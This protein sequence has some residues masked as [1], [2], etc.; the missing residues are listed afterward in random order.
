MKNKVFMALSVL[1]MLFQC[2]PANVFAA[3]STTPTVTTSVVVKDGNNEKILEE[4]QLDTATTK[5]SVDA[6]GN[7]V[8]TT[9]ATASDPTNTNQFSRAS[10]STSKTF[11]GWKGKVSINYYDDGTWVRLNSASASW[12]HVSGSTAISK[13]KELIYGQETMRNSRNGYKN[14]TGLST[15]VSPKW[16]KGK[17]A[18][19]LGNKVGANVSAKISGK[20][21]YV[22]CNVT[23]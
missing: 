9:T 11:H 8:Y 10:Q 14:F 5:K 18:Y 2:I 15:S 1:A 19:K 17:Y 6:N 3:T 21:V 23:F 4:Y 12:K 13:T 7:I 22:I 16:P 20:Y